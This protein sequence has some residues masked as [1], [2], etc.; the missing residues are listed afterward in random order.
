MHTLEQIFYKNSSR[1]TFLRNIAGTAAIATLSG[2]IPSAGIVYAPEPAVIEVA[3]SPEAQYRPVNILAGST[4]VSIPDTVT[5]RINGLNSIEMTQELDPRALFLME[6]VIEKQ[7]PYLGELVD[8]VAILTLPRS[9][10]ISDGTFITDTAMVGVTAPR[11]YDE[12]APFSLD[13][14]NRCLY[15]F[16]PEEVISGEGLEYNVTHYNLNP[17]ARAPIPQTLGD[18]FQW[19]FSHEANHLLEFHKRIHQSI[20]TS[21][22]NCELLEQYLTDP[23]LF[24]SAFV[25]TRISEILSLSS[26]GTEFLES[27]ELTKPLSFQRGT[28]TQYS[29]SRGAALVSYSDGNY[30]FETKY[31]RAA[32]YMD[33]ELINYEDLEPLVKSG[34]YPTVYTMFQPDAEKYA[35]FGAWYSYSKIKGTEDIFAQNYPDIY[36]YYDEVFSSFPDFLQQTRGAYT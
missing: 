18:I 19:V 21:D 5:E 8:E 2:C 6:E 1:R 11:K 26:I 15:L 9:T 10:P 29:L 25:G 3:A 4:E 32:G 31:A 12:E 27:D 7:Y 24:D 13:N 17:Y 22:D 36:K 16:L 28:S 20:C 30:S 14:L 35:E 23:S 34:K 33:K